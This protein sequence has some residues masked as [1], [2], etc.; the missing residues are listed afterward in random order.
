MGRASRLRFPSWTRYTRDLDDAISG[1]QG[2]V[3]WHRL[4]VRFAYCHSMCRGTMEI[5]PLW[6]EHL[7]ALR[8]LG[9]LGVGSP[10]PPVCL[11]DG[12]TTCLGPSLN[13]SQAAQIEAFMRLQP[14]ICCSELYVVPPFWP[15]GFVFDVSRD[16][17]TVAV[18]PNR[19]GFTERHYPRACPV[20]RSSTTG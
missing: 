10:Y 3:E 7:V 15:A 6:S 20:C 2:R 12:C 4:G 16:W 11:A 8:A 13:A 17:T 1:D 19:D 14:S 9:C 18:A 5:Q